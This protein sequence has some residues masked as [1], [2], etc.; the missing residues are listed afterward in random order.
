MDMKAKEALKLLDSELIYWSRLGWAEDPHAVNDQ[1]EVLL[2]EDI[3]VNMKYCRQMLGECGIGVFCSRLPVGWTGVETYNFNTADK[4]LDAL[5]AE[6]PNLYYIPRL[7]LNAPWEWQRENPDE[8]CL[9]ETADFKSNDEIAASVE[10]EKQDGR[11]AHKE[12]SVFAFQSFASKKWLNDAKKALGLMIEHLEERYGER[13][14][15]YHVE[16]GKCGETHFWGSSADHSKVNKKAFYDF[17]IEKYKSLKGLSDAWGIENITPENIVIPKNSERCKKSPELDTFFHVGKE[18]IIY[19]DYN[20]YRKVLSAELV[21]TLC[22]E[23]KDKSGGK[24]VGLFHGYII[25]DGADYHGH[26]DIEEILNSEYVDYMTAPKFYYRCKFGEPCGSHCPPMSLKRKNM[27]WIDEIDTRT[28]MPAMGKFTTGPFIP[29]I[30]QAKDMDETRWVLW[31]EFA[32]NE[33]AG[34]VCWFM[35]L[36]GGWFDD[37]EILKEMSKIYNMRKTLS[38]MKKESISEILIVVDEESHMMTT[39]DHGFYVRALQD[40]MCE[41]A[42][43]GAPYD[44]CRQKE[45]AEIDLSKY[46]LVVFLNAFLME[47][48]EF[49]K[50]NFPD[51][52]H[53]IWNYAPGYIKGDTKKLTGMNVKETGLYDNFPY[54]EIMPEDGVEVVERYGE[55][56]PEYKDIP[57]AEGKPETGIKTAVKGNNLLTVLPSVNRKII[58][59][60]AESAGCRMYAPSGDIVYADNRF[61]AIF[62]GKGFEFKLNKY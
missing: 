31:R 47:H 12:G 44:M 49:S 11:G 17:C 8:L 26:T 2:Y 43:T 16:Y 54:L 52:T 35:D 42:M 18:Y 61:T 39:Q 3:E 56:M 20:E 1:G 51:N 25:H 7:T 33:M 23:A 21:N 29:P 28:H 4:V 14:L 48:E 37:E 59:E 32:R 62:N 10:T 40:T 60:F 36:G 5:F 9:Y 6:F 57:K 41:V 30:G 55:E 53:F 15:G 58:R 22:K 50:L 45:L 34:A 27:V 13:M 46:K 38:K 19:R 24:L